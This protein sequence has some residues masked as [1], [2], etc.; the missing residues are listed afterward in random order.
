MIYINFSDEEI[1]EFNR[2]Y[3]EYC[4]DLHDSMIKL[5]KDVEEYLNKS[6]CTPLI[7]KV[8]HINGLFN[9]QF[10]NAANWGFDNW[11]S[12]DKCFLGL[13]RRLKA[14]KDSDATAIE[15]QNDLKKIFDNFWDHTILTEAYRIF[16]GTTIIKDSDVNELLEIYNR[17]AKDIVK[18]RARMFKIIDYKSSDDNTYNCMRDAVYAIDGPI[19]VFLEESCTRIK[20]MK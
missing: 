13:S 20:E 12:G 1:T 8:G 11:I 3:K 9:E 4:D 16:G 17:C 10:R 7:I 6:K 5:Q 15:I 2:L 14:G 18:I 19:S